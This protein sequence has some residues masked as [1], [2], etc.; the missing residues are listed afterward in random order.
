MGKRVKILSISHPCS[1]LRPFALTKKYT[2]KPRALPNPNRPRCVHT[3]YCFLHTHTRTSTLHEVSIPNRLR[4]FTIEIYARCLA[5]DDAKSNDSERT[6]AVPPSVSNT[7]VMV[8]STVLDNAM[9]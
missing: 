1:P 4:H 5:S 6:R 2:P 7:I 9:N 3:N 8:D